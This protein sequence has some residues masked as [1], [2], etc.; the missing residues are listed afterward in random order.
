MTWNEKCIIAN[1]SLGQLSTSALPQVTPKYYSST[2]LSLAFR[3]GSYNN[4][5]ASNKMNNNIES[6][7]NSPNKAVKTKF[8]VELNN[9]YSTNKLK[10]TIILQ[11]KGNNNLFIQS[12]VIDAQHE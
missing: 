11:I 3:E 1:P 6:S 5:N 4:I 2:L 8:K 10:T 12:K 7:H 9:E